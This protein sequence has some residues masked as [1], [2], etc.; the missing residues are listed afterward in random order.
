MGDSRERFTAAD[1]P[2][3]EVGPGFRWQ[4]RMFVALAENAMGDPDRAAKTAMEAWERGIEDGVPVASRPYQAQAMVL[5]QA[6]RGDLL[7][8]ILENVEDDL[9]AEVRESAGNWLSTPGRSARDEWRSRG[10]DL[11]ARGSSH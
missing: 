1:R 6:G 3:I 8:M 9:T 2:A 11:F 10:G 5:G 7:D 4:E